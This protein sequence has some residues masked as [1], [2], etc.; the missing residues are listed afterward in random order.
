MNIQKTLRPLRWRLKTTERRLILL[1][2]DLIVSWLGLV[3]SLYFWSQRDQWLNFSFEF[4]RVRPASWFYLLPFIWMLL[5]IELYDVRRSSRL[6]DTIRG[7]AIAAGISFVIYFSVFFFSEPNSLPSTGVAGFII[8]TSI[9]TIIWRLLYINVFTAQQFMRR[10]VIVGAGRAGTNLVQALHTIKPMPFHIVGFIDD[11]PK[12]KGKQIEKV[13]VIGD[14][15]DLL[16]SWK[17]RIFQT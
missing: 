11:D 15:N 16:A 8:A 2:G 6:N 12:K 10:V 17:K 13:P 1:L 9:L 7:V 4:F 5:I 3:I 14:G